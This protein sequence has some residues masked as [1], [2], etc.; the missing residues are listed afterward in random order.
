M[1][2]AFRTGLVS[3][4]GRPNVGKSTLLNRL[5]GQKIS[6]TS[7]KPQTT[8]HNIIGV[9]HHER[10]QIVF[11]DTPG[12]HQDAKRALNRSINRA[13]RAAL[14]GVDVHVVVVEVGGWRGEDDR[15]LAAVRETGL[16]IVLVINKIDKL[17]S[18]DEILPVI[19]A[20]RQRADFAEIVPLAA[21]RGTN[22]DSLTACLARYLP[23]ASAIYDEEQVT[24][25][26]VQ[27]LA[28]ELV[29]EQLFRQL[30]DELP[31]A[32]TVR[33]EQMERHDDIRYVNA[34]IVVESD[35]QKGIVVGKRGDRL[36]TI[37]TRARQALENML[38]E[39]V[40]LDVWVTVRKGW[41]DDPAA[42]GELGLSDS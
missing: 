42:L 33:I 19:D 18:K 22:V 11:V 34:L 26:S 15:V 6:I 14:E 2:D 35:S 36:K 21:R 32:T 27:F 28:A 38:A 23:V 5:V 20:Y 1:T 12:L 29:R 31:Y 4:S 17:S 10:Y 40:Y 8:R 7:S 3:I 13:A 41:T 16:P 25:R 39:K 37:A 24:D 30:G 9:Y